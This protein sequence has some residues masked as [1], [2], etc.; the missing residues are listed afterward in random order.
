MREVGPL[1][2]CG[3]GPQTSDLT[4]AQVRGRG[5]GAGQGEGG[6]KTQRWERRWQQ[7]HHGQRP[8]QLDARTEVGEL[9]LQTASQEG[10]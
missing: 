1:A 5:E 6:A 3:S 4:R 2:A 9:L 10:W 7:Q 8:W